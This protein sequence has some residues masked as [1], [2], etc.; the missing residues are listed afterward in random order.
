MYGI[1]R[2]GGIGV[3]DCG[4]VMNIWTDIEYRTQVDYNYKAYKGRRISIEPYYARL[5]STMRVLPSPKRH[6][7]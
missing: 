2:D 5:Y 7:E 6:K 1:F 3:P 4:E